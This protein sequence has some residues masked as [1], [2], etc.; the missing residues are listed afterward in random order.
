MLML[1]TDLLLLLVPRDEVVY[2]PAQHREPSWGL[3][4][5]VHAAT[6]LVVD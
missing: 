2:L 1:M 3:V 6:R 4:A 5:V